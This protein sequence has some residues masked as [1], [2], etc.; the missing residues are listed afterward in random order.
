MTAASDTEM[1]QRLFDQALDLWVRPE[2][3]RRRQRGVII[4]EFDLRAAQVVMPSPV[5]DQVLR[6]RL[7]EE[8]RAVASVKLRGSVEAGDSIYES[9]VEEIREMRLTDEEDPNSGHLTMMRVRGNWH[10]H[11]DFRRDR[12][13]AQ[14]HLDRASD[15]LEAAKD[16]F[17]ANRLAPAVDN[18][19]SAAELAAR[20]EL[21][22]CGFYPEKPQKTHP[23]TK[24]WYNRWTN[25]GNAPVESSAVLNKL[26]D[27]R[28]K[29]RYVEGQLPTGSHHEALQAVGRMI[30]HARTRLRQP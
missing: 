9:Q 15:F 12:A 11:F 17:S 6:V 7:N 29:A 28:P 3:E 5:D 8:V 10:I 4:G 16:S 1:A 2:I 18:L 20:A 30:E 13:R 25:L 22:V 23:S 14:E 21:M 24:S 27:L 19:F 26:A